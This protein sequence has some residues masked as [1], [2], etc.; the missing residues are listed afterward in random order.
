MIS[1]SRQ[2]QIDWGFSEKAA[3]LAQVGGMTRPKP[4][5]RHVNFCCAA[6]RSS[7]RLFSISLGDKRFLLRFNIKLFIAKPFL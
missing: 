4:D 5:I 2:P 3:I 6:A 7:R 1:N